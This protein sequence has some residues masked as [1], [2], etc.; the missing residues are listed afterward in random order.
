M[1]YAL[2]R[3]STLSI[4]ASAVIFA[5][6]PTSEVGAEAQLEIAVSFKKAMSAE[7]LDGRVLV[8][9]STD[10]SAEP[11]FQIRGGVKSQQVFG[12]DVEGLAPGT[13]EGV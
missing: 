8:M 12:V 7:P 6:A 3:R 1:R 4:F 9:L 2:V 13:A 5:C 10:D 11:R